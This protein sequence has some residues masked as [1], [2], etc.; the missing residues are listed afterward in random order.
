MAAHAITGAI[1]A[2]GAARIAAAAARAAMATEQPTIATTRACATR[3]A[4]AAMSAEQPAIAA[5]G[6]AATRRAAAAARAAVTLTLTAEKAEA[7]RFAA[8]A[9]TAAA[10]S[11]SDGCGNRLRRR[12]ALWARLRSSPEVAI[13]AVPAVCEATAMTQPATMTKTATV[14]DARPGAVASVQTVATIQATTAAGTAVGNVH[15]ATRTMG[16][17]MTARAGT[18]GKYETFTA[19]NAASAEAGCSGG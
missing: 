13:H 15:D 1:A 8:N 9:A 3:R 4:A 19:A 5:T 2:G 17:S 7:S 16:M 10:I 14:D 18:V 11:A 12:N 6:I